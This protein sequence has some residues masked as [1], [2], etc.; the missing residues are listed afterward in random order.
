MAIVWTVG[1][2]FIVF[3]AVPQINIQHVAEGIIGHGL[4]LGGDYG[5]DIGPCEDVLAYEER[6]FKE[7]RISR[8]AVA[9]NPPKFSA[10]SSALLSI[11]SDSP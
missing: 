9:M 7:A 10:Y 6:K 11:P 2:G 3:L 4:L 1:P 5:V 8:R